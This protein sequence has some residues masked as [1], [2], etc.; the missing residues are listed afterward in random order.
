[1]RTS[2]LD[3]KIIR[4]L[5]QTLH[6]KI[7]IA[8]S[9]SSEDHH[10]PLFVLP[11]KKVICI[12]SPLNEREQALVQLILEQAGEG[13][14]SRED[15]QGCS[16]A[17]WLKA[18]REEEDLFFPEEVLQL[19]WN[20][21][22]PFLLVF[23]AELDEPGRAEIETLLEGYFDEQQAWIIPMDGREWVIFTPEVRL[24]EEEHSVD[25]RDE[26][27]VQAAEG[28]AE[29]VVNE[30]G[31]KVRIV[32]HRAISSPQE[33]KN[34]W[35]HMLHSY[36]LGRKFHPD[37]TVY[38]SWNLGLEQLLQSLDADVAETFLSRFPFPEMFLNEE[39]R[40]TIEMFFQMNLNISET[41]RRLYIHRNTL[42]YRLDR[43]KQETGL[44][45]RRFEDAVL[46]KMSML[47]TR[48][49]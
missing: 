20:T 3:A 2:D 35:V 28:L 6:T 39:M 45:L 30:G 17:R 37:R 31:K 32:V 26:N 9:P 15:E 44:D 22:V 19:D 29:A 8:D 18:A 7:R 4:R 16:L 27:L 34:M 14:V 47:L 10:G 5:E 23:E 49:Q 41:A 46:A 33:V 25:E 1:M 48:V 40:K 13:G 21:R 24:T 36:R 38:A 12:E 43:F 42:L 11:S